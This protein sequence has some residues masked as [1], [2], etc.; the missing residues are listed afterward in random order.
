MSARWKNAT[1]I[2][3]VKACMHARISSK[4]LFMIVSIKDQE[5]SDIQMTRVRKLKPQL[6]QDAC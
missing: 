5:Y 3:N 2:R 1:N 6:M 4:T